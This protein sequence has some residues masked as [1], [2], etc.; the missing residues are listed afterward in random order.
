MMVF[1]ACCCPFSE[2]DSVN[3]RVGLANG[4]RQ[5]GS[6]FGEVLD[7]FLRASDAYQLG[8]VKQL[9]SDPA[10]HASNKGNLLGERNV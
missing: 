7:H 4:N 9:L 2:I 6:G 10:P 3:R 8:R 1:S 5:R